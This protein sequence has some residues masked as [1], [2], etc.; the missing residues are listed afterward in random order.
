MLGSAIGISE[1]ILD[2]RQVPVGGHILR[3]LDE[4]LLEPGVCLP[5]AWQ[6]PRSIEASGQRQ[7]YGSQ[8]VE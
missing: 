1:Q 7:V 5:E 6:L 3:I 2:L 4:G 8:F